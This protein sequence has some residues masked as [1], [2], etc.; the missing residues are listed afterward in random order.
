LGL[1]ARFFAA[2]FGD[3]RRAAARDVERLKLFVTALILRLKRERVNVDA[4]RELAM[5]RVTWP[6]M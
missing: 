3:E 5:G 4:K 1:A 2:V 6:H